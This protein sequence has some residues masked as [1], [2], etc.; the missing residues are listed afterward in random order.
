MYQKMS[1]FQGFQICAYFFSSFSGCQVISNFVIFQ[2]INAANIKVTNGAT[3]W[4]KPAADLSL[5]KT[6]IL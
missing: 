6:K 1:K 4:Q 3:W 5:L 2:K